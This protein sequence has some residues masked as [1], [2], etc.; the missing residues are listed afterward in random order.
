MWR[1][2][3]FSV[4]FVLT[5]YSS[6][7]TLG[8]MKKDIETLQRAYPKIYLACHADHVKAKSTEFHLSAR[9]SSIL[10]HLDEKK[11]QTA[12][13]LALHLGV[14]PST[15]SAALKQM[16]ALGYVNRRADPKDGRTALLTLSRL[17]AR[18]MAATSVLDANKVKALLAELQLAERREALA[19]ITLLAEAA[20][21]A[22]A[23]RAAKRKG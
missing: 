15:F 6:S 23:R 7:F 16:V 13:A 18:A 5:N 10:S 17:G 21:R 11:P 19:G 1:G 22:Q 12:Q 4:C 8:G 3:H 2:A 20:G 9:D 14:Q